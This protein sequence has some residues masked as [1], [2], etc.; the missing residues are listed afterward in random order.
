MLKYLKA[1]SAVPFL[2][3]SPITING[4][5]LVDGGVSDPLPILKALVA[6][7]KHIVVIRTVNK[8]T[9]QSSW[10]QRVDALPIRRALPAIMLDMLEIHEAAYSRAIDVMRSPPDGVQ[11]YTIAPE[12]ALR[13]HAFGSSSDSIIDDYEQGRAAGLEAIT[14]LKAS[15]P[16]KQE[17]KAKKEE[18]A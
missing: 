5:Q 15:L 11:I 17:N 13:S 8:D 14:R 4:E 10:R 2:Y 16:A 9:V 7:A 1:S 6:G 12:H 3:R 18:L